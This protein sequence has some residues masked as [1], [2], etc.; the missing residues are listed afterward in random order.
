MKIKKITVS[1]F[2]MTM[3]L[4]TSAYALA[5][6]GSCGIGGGEHPHASKG[7]G[8]SQKRGAEMETYTGD[9]KAGSCFGN[10]CSLAEDKGGV[11]EIT[12]EQFQKIRNSGEDYVLLDALSSESYRSGHIEGAVSLPVNTINAESAGS[13]LKKT[14]NIVVYCGSFKCSAS[15]N[16]ARALQKLGYG[17]VLDYKGGLQEWEEK[18]NKLVQ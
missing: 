3:M 4:F 8:Y 17:N 14:D 10:V 18:G 6:C 13:L 2:V 12:Y 15:T 9:K 16:A 11:K 1:L 7:S 5:H